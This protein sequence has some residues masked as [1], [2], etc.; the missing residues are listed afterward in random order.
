MCKPKP[1]SA[2]AQRLFRRVCPEAMHP[3]ASV[4]CHRCGSS[5]VGDGPAISVLCAECIDSFR[6][7]VAQADGVP[8][9]VS[10]LHDA[11]EETPTA[12]MAGLRPLDRESYPDG[13]TCEG[14]G[15]A[16]AWRGGRAR[17]IVR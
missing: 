17:R 16:F 2:R 11:A 7:G 10:C 8:L 3:T 6:D 13:Y 5:V 4:E 14:C 15:D 12:L 9:C 1:V